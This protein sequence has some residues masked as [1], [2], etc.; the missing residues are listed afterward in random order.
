MKYVTDTGKDFKCVVSFLRFWPPCQWQ[1]HY[2][3]NL[4]TVNASIND[5]EIVAV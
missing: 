3:G 5:Q 1:P 2:D 4:Q